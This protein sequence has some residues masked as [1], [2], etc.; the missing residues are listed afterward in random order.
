MSVITSDIV[1]VQQ[2]PLLT[3][4]DS[5]A[6]NY[7]QTS[8]MQNTSV[9]T[10]LAKTRKADH[11]GVST[12]ETRLNICLPLWNQS[13]FRHWPH[14][15]DGNLRTSILKKSLAAAVMM[16]NSGYKPWDRFDA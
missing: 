2:Y 12:C 14:V 3:W 15:P 16:A 8:E 13:H 9:T 11:D 1:Q 6:K 10:E 7:V 5:K 4:K